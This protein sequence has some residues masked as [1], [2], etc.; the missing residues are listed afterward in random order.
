MARGI[1]VRKSFVQVLEE[2]ESF[3]RQH[4]HMNVPQ[5]YT[6]RDGYALGRRCAYL[7][8]YH[9]KGKL[10][11]Q[12]FQALD[13]IGFLW[14]PNEELFKRKAKEFQEW[15]AKFE[16]YEDSFNPEH[17]QIKERLTKQGTRLKTWLRSFKRYYIDEIQGNDPKVLTRLEI[18]SQ[19]NIPV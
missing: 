4:G 6:T 3:Q 12:R 19:Y 9:K 7:R 5:S 16:E 17:D 15:A 8:F 14:S 18:L 10:S 1:G 2:L 13:D 11:P